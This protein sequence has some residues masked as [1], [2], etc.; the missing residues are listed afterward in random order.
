MKTD[1]F[2]KPKFNSF[3]TCNSTRQAKPHYLLKCM[4]SDSNTKLIV[5]LESIKFRQADR[6]TASDYR[7]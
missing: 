2:G 1:A 3:E 5:N 7:K 6:Q 4:E